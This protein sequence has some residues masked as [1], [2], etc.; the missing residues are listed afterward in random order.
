MEEIDQIAKDIKTLTIQ[1]ARNVAI[2][3]LRAVKIA[4]LNADAGSPAELVGELE[5]VARRV[6][7]IRVTEPALR[8]V[9]ATVLA[10]SRGLKGPTVDELRSYAARKCDEMLNVLNANIPKIINVGGT[11]IKDGSTVFTHC[12]SSSVTSLIIAE[13]KKKDLRVICT[14]TRPKWQGRKTANELAKN[15]VDTTLFVDSAAYMYMDEA[16]MVLIG[17]DAVGGG[18]LYNKIGSYMVVHFANMKK[19]PAYSVC[20]TQKFDPL[21]GL[22]YLQPVEQ[23]PASEVIEGEVPFNVRNPAFEMVPLD[24]IDALITE[25]GIVKPRDVDSIMHTYD[26]LVPELKKLVEWDEWEEES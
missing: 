17:A 18:F 22:G 7:L 1:G 11:V 5:R 20:E 26:H 19:I 4:A 23:R 21:V 24:M 6:S 16:D 3:G 15:G 12:H 8:N 9:L 25:A 10:S 13:S 2:A 14:E